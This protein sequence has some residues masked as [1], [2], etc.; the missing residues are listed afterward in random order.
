ME[1]LDLNEILNR[2]NEENTMMSLLQQFDNNKHDI[3]IKRNIYIYGSSGIGKTTF[4][5]NILKKMNYDIVKYDASDIRNKSVIEN[6]AHH[7]MSDKN[8]ISMFRNKV[9][10]IAVVMDEI[11]GMN[12]GDKGGINSLIKIIRPKKTKKQKLEEQT[13]NPIICIGNYHIDKKINELMKVCNIIELK[14][15]TTEQINTLITLL[16]PNINNSLKESMCDFI[17]RDLTKF[18]NVYDIYNNTSELLRDDLF[19]NI[20]R[21]KSFNENTKQI[22]QH[23]FLK[24][25]S[26]FEHNNVINDTDRTIV[27]LL[28]HENVINH[29][30][31]EPNNISIPFYLK[32]LNNICFSDYI[33]RITFQKQIWQFN[34]MTSLIKTFYNNKLY[35]EHINLNPKYLNMKLL[36]NTN[37]I[38]FTKVLTKYSTEYN[39]NNFIQ[40]MCQCLN[41]E[42][43]D[44]F[45]LFFYIRD[46]YKDHEIYSFFEDTDITK[47]D[48][49]RL[50]R[51]LDK[52]IYENATGL[53]EVFIQ[54]DKMSEDDIVDEAI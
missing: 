6:I 32:I 25:N 28:W 24:P 15:P 29:I 16:L 13:R 23:L 3:S 45:S 30:Q 50:C 21:K 9:K 19:H 11:D 39:N 22:T 44:L 1:N 34:E 51:F 42:R 40:N 33:D 36:E 7:N 17:Q 27:G 12:N 4:V 20:F 31:K 41:I 2:K 47:L 35:H 49:N 38:R 5:V 43:K 18:A 14:P 37:N 54:E 52:Y 8:I 10:N 46:K 48:I 26:I 53:T